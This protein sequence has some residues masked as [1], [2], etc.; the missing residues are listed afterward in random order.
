VAQ[1]RTFALH[2]ADPIALSGSI[3]RKLEQS[4]GADQKVASVSCSPAGVCDATLS[5]DFGKYRARLRFWLR[6]IAPRN[7]HC[8]RLARWAVT[9]PTHAPGAENAA[10]PLV[11]DGCAY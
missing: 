3:K 8:Y 4:A 7:L 6:G 11:H 1:P 5:T 9:Q 10:I 2:A